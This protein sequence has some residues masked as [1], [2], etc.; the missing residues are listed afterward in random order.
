MSLPQPHSAS[1]TKAVEKPL[2]WGSLGFPRILEV[3][4]ALMLKELLANGPGI[5]ETLHSV[6]NL[7]T[8]IIGL[9]HRHYFLPLKIRDLRFRG[10]K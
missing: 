5:L 1:W 6:H 10:V 3:G 7:V 8:L 2:P 9:V 4:R